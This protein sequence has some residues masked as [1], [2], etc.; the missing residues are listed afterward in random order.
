VQK[1]VAG[2]VGHFHETKA[3]LGIIPFY[4]SFRFWYRG[5]GPKPG[6]RWGGRRRVAKKIVVIKT[7]AAWLTL[8]VVFRGSHYL[9]CP[10]KIDK[11]ARN[12]PSHLSIGHG[13]FPFNAYQREP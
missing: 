8:A 13:L 5:G 9:N 6:K 11:P 7:A 12:L 2:T 1:N 3:F 4:G 10:L